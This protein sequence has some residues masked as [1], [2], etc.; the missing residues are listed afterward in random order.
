MIEFNR[1]KNQNI[2]I[3]IYLLYILYYYYI[4]IWLSANYHKNVQMRY[5]TIIKNY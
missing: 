4:Y 3:N 2:L 5:Y 1:N